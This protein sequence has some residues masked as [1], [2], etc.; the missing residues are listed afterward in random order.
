MMPLPFGL[1]PLTARRPWI[2]PKPGI[3]KRMRVFQPGMD[4]VRLHGIFSSRHL[5]LLKHPIFVPPLFL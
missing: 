2:S 5:R 4:I 3:I 1:T